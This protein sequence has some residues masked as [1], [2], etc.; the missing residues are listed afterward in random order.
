M[1]II[2]KDVEILLGSSTESKATGGRIVYFNLISEHEASVSC[3]AEHK[4][5]VK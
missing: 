1:I 4:H 3:P 5:G 2:K